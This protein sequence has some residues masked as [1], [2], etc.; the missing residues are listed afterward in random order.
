M[1]SC[2]RSA[3]F[4]C[5]DFSVTRELTKTAET[6]LHRVWGGWGGGVLCIL[7]GPHITTQDFPR[8]FATAQHEQ[9]CDFKS[10]GHPAAGLIVGATL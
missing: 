2:D 10:V 1:A 4:G 3:V 7:V 9:R 8:L 5:A 6:L